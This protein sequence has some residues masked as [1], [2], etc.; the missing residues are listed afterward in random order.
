MRKFLNPQLPTVALRV[1]KVR[2]DPP[3]K[4]EAQRKQQRAS[5]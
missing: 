3:V 4:G 1:L 5:G 2:G